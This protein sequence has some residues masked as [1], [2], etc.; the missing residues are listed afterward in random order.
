LGRLAAADSAAAMAARARLRQ[1]RDNAARG[2]RLSDGAGLPA[3]WITGAA[4]SAAGPA[5]LR[6]P[7]AAVQRRCAAAVYAM[8]RARIASASSATATP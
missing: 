2:G 4:D 3:A 6:Q 8:D 7:A 5:L 1:S